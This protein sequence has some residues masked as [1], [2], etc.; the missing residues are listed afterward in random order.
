MDFLIGRKPKIRKNTQGKK[1]NMIVI[2][3]FAVSNSTVLN[4]EL[5]WASTDWNKEAEIMKSLLI[6]PKNVTIINR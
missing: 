2:E 5:N 4:Q 6:Q 1:Q 3:Q